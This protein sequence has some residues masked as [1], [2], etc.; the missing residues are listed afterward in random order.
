EDAAV[1]VVDEDGVVDALEEGAGPGLRPPGR[2]RRGRGAFGRVHGRALRVC[3]VRSPAG[4]FTRGRRQ[5]GRKTGK[6]KAVRPFKGCRWPLPGLVPELGGCRR[7]RR[8][9][10]W[11]P[12]GRAPGSGPPTR[13]P[14]APRFA[15]PKP[16]AASA[17]RQPATMALL[18]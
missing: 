16:P 15:G 7:P 3:A 1:E 17:R 13:S 12:G 14:R 10:G 11:L 8:A 9:S 5:R 2:F 18:R 4:D 6:N